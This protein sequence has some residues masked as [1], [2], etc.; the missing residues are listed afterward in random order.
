MKSVLGMISIIIGVII[1]IGGWYYTYFPWIETNDGNWSISY[2]QNYC[3]TNPFAQVFASEDCAQIESMWT[4]GIGVI[5]IGGVFFLL[6]FIAAIM[7]SRPKQ[8]DNTKIHTTAD[9]SWGAKCPNCEAI[10]ISNL[11]TLQGQMTCGNC[12]A[13]FSPSSIEKV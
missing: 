1:L 2:A 4:L 6:G 12:K 5:A 7:P 10:N 9:E 8:L 11:N 13:V 3:E